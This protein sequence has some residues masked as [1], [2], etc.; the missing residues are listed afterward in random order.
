M[1]QKSLYRDS[2]INYMLLTI[3]LSI[4]MIAISSYLTQH[5]F[6]VKFPTGLSTG[7][8]CN[9]NGFFNCDKTT[10]SP[11]GA[12]FN[13]PISIF[14]ILIGVFALLGTII[15]ND[16]YERS[17]YFALIVNFIGC[18][19]LFL[20]SLFVLHGLCPF[21]TFYYIVSGAILFLFYKKSEK[22]IPNIGVTLVLAI[23]V[24]IP[25]YF[26]RQNIED[27]LNAQSSISNDLI[28]Q[29]YSLPNLGGPNYPS[30]FKLA[31][32]AN[33]AIKMVIFSDFECP[34]CKALSEEVPQIIARYKD[35]V[36]ILYY[37]YPLDNSCNPEMKRPLH[38]YACKAAKAAICMPSA[39]F[40]Q[41]HET[42]FKN[43]DQ[44]E[45][46]FVDQYI[47]SNKLEECINKESTKDTLS[48]IIAAAAPFNIVSTPTYLINGVKIEGVLPPDQLF[49]ILDEI[50]KRA[51]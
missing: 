28:K 49:S 34:A 48:K 11:M 26:T 16:E 39:D 9:I 5:F 24:A 23:V 30:I 20:Y 25:A 15:K 46:G 17:V 51:K 4:L 14:G 7:S 2:N 41:I 32:N 27:R 45:A 38:Q 6:E 47:K 50:V 10:N 33:P 19:S 12:P 8:I 37:F 13:I 18:V 43:Q 42:F 29:F 21:C 35:K 3:L 36:E 22:P 40:Y 31:T 1:K 44:F